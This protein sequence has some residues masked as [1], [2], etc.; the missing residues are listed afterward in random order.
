MDPPKGGSAGGPPTD[1]RRD[2]PVDLSM[3]P[4][5]VPQW[6]QHA[7]TCAP[8]PQGSPW[9]L[10]NPR[11]ANMCRNRLL[12]V[13]IL[14]RHPL[15]SSAPRQECTLW[16]RTPR[17]PRRNL[18]DSEYLFCQFILSCFFSCFVSQLKQPI[19]TP[20]KKGVLLPGNVLQN[21][22][23]TITAYGLY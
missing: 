12:L 7:A 22:Q 16:E 3:D 23:L 9:S 15:T 6:I 10:T 17:P 8:P 1:P 13:P 2:P 18:V 5:E 14:P 20:V 4:L 19:W 21:K 11:A